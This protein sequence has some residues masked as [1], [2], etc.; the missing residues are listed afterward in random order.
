MGEGGQGAR[1]TN[2]AN[3]QRHNACCMMYLAFAGQRTIKQIG[4]AAPPFFFVYLLSICS[5]IYIVV[6]GE[7]SVGRGAPIFDIFVK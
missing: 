1:K 6:N 2:Q 4:A 5:Q 7:G 3:Q